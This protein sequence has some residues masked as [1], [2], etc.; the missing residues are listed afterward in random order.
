MIY[1]EETIR[2]TG[3][4]G[5]TIVRAFDDNGS[6]DG[7]FREIYTDDGRGNGDFVCRAV[8]KYWA[9]TIAAALDAQAVTR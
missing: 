4:P 1:D 3:T 2:R 6:P 8:S 9:E 7:E 5:Y